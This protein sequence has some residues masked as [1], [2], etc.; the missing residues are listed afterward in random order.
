MNPGPYDLQTS[1]SLELDDA[2]VQLFVE[3]HG[4]RW[5]YV[6]GTHNFCYALIEGAFQDGLGGTV[7]NVRR[8]EAKLDSFMSQK[9]ASFLRHLGIC[10]QGS[11]ASAR[12]AHDVVIVLLAQY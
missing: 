6:V 5:V 4:C 2:D 7:R 12:D 8:R 11:K 1:L 3:D 10:Q 9:L